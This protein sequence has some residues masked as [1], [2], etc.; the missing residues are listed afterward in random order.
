MPDNVKTVILGA[1]I[2]GLSAAHHYSQS[3]LEYALYEAKNSPGG[4][5]DGFSVNG[6]HFDQAIHLSFA[7]ESEVRKI[8]DETTSI[9]HSPEAWCWHYDRWLKHPAHNN[10]NA[11]PLKDKI[12]LITSFINK[13]DIEVK[14]YEDWLV[15]QYGS[16]IAKKWTLPYTEKYWTIPANKLGTKWIGERVKKANLDEIL[17]GALTPETPTYYYAPEMRYPKVGGYKTF[18]DPLIKNQSINVNCRAV[19]IDPIKKEILFENGIS[20]YY[21]NLIN[22]I[23]LPELIAIMSDVPSKVISASEQ[24]HSTSIDLVS[25]GFDVPKIQDKLWFYIYDEDILSARCHSPSEKSKNNAPSGQSS[26]QFEIYSSRYKPQTKSIEELKE[27]V[28]YALFKMGIIKSEEEIL[29]IDH[30]YIPYANVIFDLGMEER[31]DSILS[32]LETVDV[33]PA[34]RFGEWKYLWSNQ[35]FMSGKSA[36]EE[37]LQRDSNS[38][39]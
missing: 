12:E 10:L 7:N 39:N 37:V 22:T 16:Q 17:Y 9:T 4:L 15:N 38:R 34:G 13:K 29:F 11:L 19:K 18:L 31:R 30:K 21:K 8:F 6:F 1:G 36:A 27:N 26:L 32:W 20:I 14:N 2:S 24:L 35:A 33:V 5:L 3:D 25:V 28:I 23:P